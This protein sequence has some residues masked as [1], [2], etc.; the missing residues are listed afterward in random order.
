MFKKKNKGEEITVATKG[1]TYYKLKKAN[2]LG[3]QTKYIWIT[4]L[5]VL[6]FAVGYLVIDY[7]VLK[8]WTPQMLEAVMTKLGLSKPVEN[9]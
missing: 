7:F 9:V 4:L 6:I 2:H 5:I 3:F 8:M 1:S